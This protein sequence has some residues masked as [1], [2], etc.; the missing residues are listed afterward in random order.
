MKHAR[1]VLI[2]VMTLLAVVPARAASLT[3]LQFGSFETREEAEKRLTEL[4][5]KHGKALKSLPSSVREIALSSGNLTVYRAQAGPIADRKAAQ[6]VCAALASGGDE[7]YIVNT[8]MVAADQLP[9][10][11]NV[12]PAVVVDAAK[13]EASPV[14]SV[15]AAPVVEAKLVPEAEPKA[16]QKEQEKKEVM[17]AE[18]NDAK[19]EKKR[20]KAALESESKGEETS[21]IE[22]IETS[23][24]DKDKPRA[25]PSVFDT[26]VAPT[27]APAAPVVVA[28]AIAPA[29]TVRAESVA[30]PLP[31]LHTENV[32]S[33]EP[34][35]V[36]SGAK[37]AVSKPVAAKPVVVASAAPK[38]FTM[39][40]APE[41]THVASAEPQAAEL[42]GVPSA[43]GARASFENPPETMMVLPPPP[44]PLLHATAAANT[45]IK[46]VEREIKPAEVKKNEPAPLVVALDPAPATT[47]V[48][49]VSR[50]TGFWSHLNPFEG[51]TPA[52]VQPSASV[53]E[54]EPVPLI[55]DAPAV[56][57]QLA[58]MPMVEVAQS[59]GIAAPSNV[60]PPTLTTQAPAMPL[61]PPPAPLSR[62]DAQPQAL[63]AEKVPVQPMPAPS[64]RSAPLPQI[65]AAVVPAPLASMPQP[66]VPIMQP[67]V[68]VPPPPTPVVSRAGVSV[69]E[70]KRVPLSATPLRPVQPSLSM[71]PSVTEGTKTVWA[72]IGP[73]ANATSAYA[74][75]AN[76]RQTH[77]DFPVVRAR[78]VSDYQQK[79]HGVDKSYLRIGPVTRKGFVSYLCSAVSSESHLQCGTI[80]DLG[81]ASA[82]DVSDDAFQS[83]RYVHK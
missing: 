46:P 51:S 37:P 73:F 78:V 67:P 49:T 6:D 4:N 74:Y 69:E 77:P 39:A 10:V 70:A 52:V 80:T 38:K 17:P 35:V 21:T 22:T 12:P 82:M 16:A 54:R 13:P 29:K 28:G 3:M 36:S 83:Q 8:A 75:W 61:P 60:V 19:L 57:T 76:Y 34:A 42:M 50:S 9:A 53:G 62:G 45:E 56:L 71:S 2:L 14:A 7:C 63:S 47:P 20:E 31:P 40:V 68:N 25:A 43:T 18:K 33:T 5:A 79:I 32:K 23:A 64:I 44:A 41:S 48:P 15:V 55:A 72:Q 59:P 30:P 11:A 24:A 27:E 26:M 81:L 58:P 65:Q 66:V 1:L